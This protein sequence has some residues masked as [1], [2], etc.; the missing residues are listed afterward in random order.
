MPLVPY[1]R[2][3]PYKPKGKSYSF[4]DDDERQ[5]FIQQGLSQSDANILH[6]WYAPQL[7]TGAYEFADDEQRHFFQED[8]RG[9]A[10]VEIAEAE[11]KRNDPNIEYFIWGL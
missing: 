4:F 2:L 5:I 11:L 7:M 3:I 8:Y 1:N 10:L 9:I 6:H